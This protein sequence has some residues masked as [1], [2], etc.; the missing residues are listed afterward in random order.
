MINT[1]ISRAK[2]KLIIACDS[3]YWSAIE[4]ELIGDIAK[5]NGPGSRG[6]GSQNR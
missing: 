6:T 4:G 1:A 3:E 5:K 2:K